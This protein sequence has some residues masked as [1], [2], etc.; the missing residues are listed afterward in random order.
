[1]RSLKV[2]ELDLV[3]GAGVEAAPSKDKGNNGW[4]NGIDTTNAGSDD[5]ATADS[6]LADPGGFPN[7]KFDGR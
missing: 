3:A 1:M 5:G 2:E 7:G 4:G 6:K